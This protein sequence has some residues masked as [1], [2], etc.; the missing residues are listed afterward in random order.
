HLLALAAQHADVTVTD[1]SKRHRV[2]GLEG[3]ESFRIVQKFLE[4]PVASMAYRSFAQTTH[5]GIELTVSRTGVTGEYGFKLWAPADRADDLRAELIG[6]GAVEVGSDAIDVC[7]LETRF[8][9][10]ERESGGAPVTP[11]EVGLQW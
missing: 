1:V 11:S 2:F 6:L 9:N 4:F 5:G 3:P 10:I 7:R 8:V